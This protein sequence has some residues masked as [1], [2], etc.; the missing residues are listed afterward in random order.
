MLRLLNGPNQCKFSPQNSLKYRLMVHWS[1]PIKRWNE[2]NFLSPSFYLV[3]LEH[4]SLSLLR[5]FFKIQLLEP[6]VENSARASEPKLR[7]IPRPHD[8]WCF[9]VRVLHGSLLTFSLFSHSQRSNFFSWEL[10]YKRVTPE[11]AGSICCAAS[12]NDSKHFVLIV[13]IS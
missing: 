6:R 12:R 10:R 9:R 2:P 11:L 8:S 5:A 7:L 3:K 13:S 1:R 4:P